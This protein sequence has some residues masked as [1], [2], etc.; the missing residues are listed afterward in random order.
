MRQ[1]VSHPDCRATSPTA[2]LS[3]LAVGT[4]G[5]Q[6]PFALFDGVSLVQVPEP[7]TWAVLLTGVGLAGLASRRRVRR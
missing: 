2:T 3:F 1:Y 6:P 4:P 7:A 5:G